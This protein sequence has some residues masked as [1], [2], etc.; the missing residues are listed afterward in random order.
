MGKKESLK[1]TRAFADLISISRFVLDF[2]LT[3]RANCTNNNN[4]DYNRTTRAVVSSST[5]SFK[6]SRLLSRPFR[7]LFIQLILIHFHLE[8]FIHLAFFLLQ[9]KLRSFEFL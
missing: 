4:D 1:I 5:R 7:F 9:K 2:C 3:I 8:G 6:S